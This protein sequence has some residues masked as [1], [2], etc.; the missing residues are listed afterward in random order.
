MAAGAAAQSAPTAV[1]DSAYFVVAY[2]EVTP[3]GRTQAAAAMKEY[4]AAAARAAGAIRA[5]VFEQVD[6]PG[7]FV[8][9]EAW[10]DQN[11]FFEAA[12]GARS[13][14]LDT[15]KPIRLSGWDERPYKPLTLGGSGAL[16]RTNTVVVGHVD[17]SPDPKVPALLRRLAAATREESGNLRFDVLQH[18]SRPNHFT[19]VGAWRDDRAHAAHAAARHTR[20]YR[21]DVQPMTG[22]PLDN[23]LYRAID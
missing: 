9:I 12:N 15:L 20:E 11:A 7:H 16:G 4:R 2:V 21:E 18:T 1:P 6:R 22:S 13:H 8:M 3:E 17:V 14:L 10:R 19:I 5:E 23:R